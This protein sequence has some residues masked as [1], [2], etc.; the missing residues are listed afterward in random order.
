MTQINDMIYAQEIFS[1][2]LL[3]AQKGQKTW[4]L[5]VVEVERAFFGKSTSSLALASDPKLR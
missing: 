3:T 4:S 1:S 2:K 5:L